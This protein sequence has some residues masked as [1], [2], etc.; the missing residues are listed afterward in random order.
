LSE[1]RVIKCKKCDAALTEIVGENLT[2]CIQC[3]YSFKLLENDNKFKRPHAL[4][5]RIKESPEY[6]RYLNKL[7]NKKFD[8]S[9]VPEN[10]NDYKAIDDNSSNTNESLEYK[11]YLNKIRNKS[12][13][14][15]STNNKKKTPVWLTVLKWYFIISFSIGILTSF[16]R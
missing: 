5:R 15:K 1:F 16:F 13:K 10:E 8:S 4:S 14:T 11:R 3:G 6:K 2:E 9:N 7:Q 12:F